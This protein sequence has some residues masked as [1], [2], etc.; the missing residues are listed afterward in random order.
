MI[1]AGDIAQVV[2]GDALP[3]IDILDV[4]ERLA[5]NGTA[6]VNGCALL[7]VGYEDAFLRLTQTYL[8]DRFSRGGSAE[9]F[10]IGPFGSG[11]THFL[12]QLMEIARDLD[13][14]TVEVALN[15]DLDF[16][17]NLAIYKE[18]TREIRPPDTEST[19]M[20]ALLVSIFARMQTGAPAA[21]LDAWVDARLGGIEHADYELAAFGMIARRALEAYD[22]GEEA[23]FHA[24]CRWLEGDVTDRRL[25]AELN[26]SPVVRSE[27][28]LH[29]RRALLSLFQ[30]IRVVGFGGT[31]VSFDE[32]EQGLGVE[33]KKMTRI[34]S[35]LQSQI[36]AI[37]D[38]RQGSALLV[39]ALTPNF[40][41][42]M[43]SFAA[44][45]QRVAD[46][47]PGR[48]FFDGNTRA[49]RIPL[50][51]RGDPAEDLSGI[52]VRLCDLL[53][54]RHGGFLLT[55]RETVRDAV[56]RL[57]EQIAD[58]DPTTA[59]RRTMVKQT[60]AMLLTLYDA[61]TLSPSAL[62]ALPALSASPNGGE[63]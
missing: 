24:C 15:K 57:A 45:Q 39:Y 51:L 16:T 49:V 63:T 50:T 9:K 54:E 58:E 8:L 26:V 60:S 55:P 10:V 52:G 43:E 25:A 22:A 37:A 31:V 13:C 46:P 36:N 19:G 14:V 29:G 59:S 3:S 61:K 33:R 53:Y 17:Q 2:D 35:M 28:N 18:V 48:G 62:P 27:E 4:L 38:L 7:G 12:R 20:R 30:F 47:G 44:L 23:T 56:K 32:A 5:E 42:E 11:K 6:P 21:Q 1:D 40:V 34:L 41:D